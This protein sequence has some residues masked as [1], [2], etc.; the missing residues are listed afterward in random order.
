MDG[1]YEIEKV[2]RRTGDEVMAIISTTQTILSDL[3]ECRQK[4]VEAMRR[5][6]LIEEKTLLF[7]DQI[8]TIANEARKIRRAL[9]LLKSNPFL[10]LAANQDIDEEIKKMELQLAQKEES[11][12]DL[13]SV[14]KGR[15]AQL[16]ASNKCVQK[17]KIVLREKSRAFRERIEY[18]NTK[19]KE[20]AES[21]KKFKRER[22]DLVILRD[23]QRMQELI[24]EQRINKL[25]KELTR[26]KNHKGRTVDSAIWVQGVMQR[27]ETQTLRDHLKADIL[28]EKN[29]LAGEKEWFPGT[30][31]GDCTVVRD[32]A[33]WFPGNVI[34]V[35]TATNALIFQGGGKWNPG[36]LQVSECSCSGSLAVTVISDHFFPFL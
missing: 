24:I 35:N 1:D 18:I 32:G 25:N 29:F 7:R 36:T 9:G 16:S 13:R 3:V 15:E 19:E 22:E 30:V 14:R 5:Q 2:V 21:I 12:Q 20:F 27:I 8:S 17:L 28:K 6:A 11:W 10:A 34:A 4:M 26:I 31:V 23:K 33:H